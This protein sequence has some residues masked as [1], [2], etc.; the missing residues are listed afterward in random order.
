MD[1]CGDGRRDQARPARLGGEAR[2]S[3]FRVFFKAVNVMPGGP[4]Q[5]RDPLHIKSDADDQHRPTRT[6][7]VVSVERSNCV[8][9]TIAFPRR[10]AS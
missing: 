1:R 10:Q 4:Q 5:L 2:G 7:F 6:I 3:S 9:D 8:R